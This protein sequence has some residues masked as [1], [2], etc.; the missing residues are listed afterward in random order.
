MPQLPDT[1]REF[2]DQLLEWFAAHQRDLPWRRTYAPYAVWI[3]EIMLQQTQMDRA[4]GYFQRWMERFPDIA[5]VAAASEDEILT[6]WEGLGYYSRARNIHK[7]AQ[8]L[9][10]EHDGVF[11][12]T[13]KALL[14]LPGIGPYTAGA[15]LSIGFGQ[16]EPAVDANVERILARL[17]D[18]D[19]PVKTKPAQEA[20]HTAARDLLP[21]G[22]CREFN[23][24]LMELGALVCRARAPRCP[25]CPVAPFCEARRLG[26]T[27]QRPVP[28]KRPV[29]TPL[30]IVT[31]VLVHRGRLFIQKRRS[32][33]V[34]A[35]L[36]E[37]PGGRVEPEE[38][39]EN[40]VV[41]EFWEE[42][43]FA[44]KA[45][46]KITVIRHGYTTYKVTLHC[47]FCTLENSSNSLPEPVLHA[48][49]EALWTPPDRLHEFAFPA[50]HRKLI[51][52][53]Q[54]DLR[55]QTLLGG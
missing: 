31:G 37:F 27:D 11:P 40:A 25:N 39:P 26:I 17:T 43:E 3:S 41:R 45:A 19:T 55:L 5:S 51:D 33:S 35:N 36:W 20:I 10:R 28:G 50:A 16:D 38:T 47:F 8:T 53:I 7:A 21:P 49:Q 48:A 29:I 42:T 6:Y 24:A 2:Q 13:R 44:V 15:I 18:I 34:W 54:R 4:V 23:Q 12:R 9:V 14:A 30:E 46:D 32:D 1:S 52:T 22:R